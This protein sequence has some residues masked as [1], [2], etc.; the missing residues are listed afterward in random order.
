MAS[1]IVRIYQSSTTL[2]SCK[3]QGP[4]FY[5]YCMLAVARG[6]KA[7]GDS[8]LLSGY[9]SSTPEVAPVDLLSHGR[10]ANKC[11]V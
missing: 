11:A 10:R 9:L 4:T 2:G 8:E 3:L 6:E 1:F 7:I 5:M